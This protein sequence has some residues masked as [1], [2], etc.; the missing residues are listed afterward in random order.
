M[1]FQNVKEWLR[2]NIVTL[3]AYLAVVVF[4]VFVGQAAFGQGIIDEAPGADGGC[5][6]ALDHPGG[7]HQFADAVDF[8]D[9]YAGSFRD[10]EGYMRH[11]F[12]TSDGNEIHYRLEVN[13]RICPVEKGVLH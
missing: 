7:P 8:I 1:N 4:L 13:R 9:R 10:A 3:L 5:F 2:D 6:Y 11:V 12:E